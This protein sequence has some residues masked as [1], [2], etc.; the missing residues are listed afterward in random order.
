[1]LAPGP[2]LLPALFIG[3]LILIPCLASSQSFQPVDSVLKQGA[4]LPLSKQ[5]FSLNQKADS[6]AAI[7]PPLALALAG[8]A[9]DL[10]KQ[11]KIAP[12]QIEALRIIGSVYFYQSQTDSAWKYFRAAL[13][14]TNDQTPRTDVAYILNALAACYQLDLNLDAAILEYEN[15]LKLGLTTEEAP[16]ILRNLYHNAAH[17]FKTQENYPKA[18][19]WFKKSM[20]ISLHIRD[21]S[22][23]IST[24]NL[25]GDTYREAKNYD[26]AMYCLRFAHYLIVKT[27][28]PRERVSVVNN[29]GAVFLDQGIYDSASVYFKIG[30][31]ISQQDTNILGISVIN[32]NLGRIAQENQRYQEA[33][34]LFGISLKVAEDGQLTERIL[35]G[36]KE[37]HHTLAL[38]GDFPQAYEIQQRYVQLKDSL[39]EEEGREKI[40]R[41]EAKLMIQEKEQEKQALLYANQLRTIWLTGSLLALGLVLIM[42]GVLINRYRYKSKLSELLEAQNLKIRAQS[43]AIAQKNFRMEKSLN[44]LHEFAFIVS[45]N[46]REPLRRIGS[47]IS[48]INM[49]YASSLPAEAHEFMGYSVQ[50]VQDL[51]HMLDD[52]L[53]YVIVEIENH[54]VRPVNTAEIVE[55]VRL[56]IVEELPGTEITIVQSTPLP[57]ITSSPNLAELLF[58]HIIQNSV[59]FRSVQ[60]PLIDISAI[61]IENGYLFTIADN[62]VGIDSMSIQKV[63]SLFYKGSV[64]E[65]YGGTGIGLS[66]C[67]KIVN[68]HH[69]EIWAESSPANG[70]KIHFTLYPLG[71]Q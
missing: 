27:D 65:E 48:L 71:T 28:N 49:R 63:F 5:I 50:G 31:D 3:L 22:A 57:V 42:A 24:Q 18:I 70:T 45:H 20:D 56:K 51:K 11:E 4:D 26:S 34:R 9:H 30:L 6:L 21:S 66:I 53:S 68:L 12:E 61:Q 10:A 17:I 38:K 13:K 36:M 14:L 54:E 46:L 64:S 37:L 15:I 41:L 25:I 67:K 52:L 16:R 47:Y 23:V 55:T 33:I 32:Y 58:S 43:E 60:P 1:M 29:I 62:G 19:S 59:K 40:A 7:N 69:G 44:E 39:S 8:K 35:Y 2:I